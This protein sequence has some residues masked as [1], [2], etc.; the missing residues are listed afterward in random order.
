MRAPRVFIDAPLVAGTVLELPDDAALHLRRVLRLAEGAA[1]RVFNG[2]GG[3]W[4]AA[5]A[6]VGRNRVEVRIAEH[7][8]VERESPIA[9]TLAQGISRAERMDY[10]L[11]KAV[12]LGVSAIAPVLTT[13][14][15]VQLGE[16]RRSRRAA[17]WTKVIRSACEQC[18][19]NRLPRLLPIQGLDAWLAADPPGAKWTLSG[20]GEQRLS[21]IDA[22]PQTLVLLVGPEG[23]LA[24]EEEVQ[25]RQAGY[26][27]LWLGP[28]TLRTETAAVAA[29][30]AIQGLWGDLR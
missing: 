13:R 3:E 9:I 17:R 1:L 14:S 23:G 20:H 16:E 30:A 10:T 24:P 29:L 27:A 22:A 5:I 26:A 7:D 19:R 12:E 2:R 28:R 6:R 11:Q 25:A 4:Q 15:V 18:G 8:P 21:A